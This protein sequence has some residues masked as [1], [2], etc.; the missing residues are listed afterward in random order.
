MPPPTT[1][2]EQAASMPKKR[3]KGGMGGGRASQARNQTLAMGCVGTGW[4][5]GEVGRAPTSK[6]KQN[7][8]E[9]Y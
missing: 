4:T 3:G 1:L 5:A 2:M 8:F 9:N 6:K 7:G